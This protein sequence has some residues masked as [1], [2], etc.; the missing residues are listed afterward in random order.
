MI[1]KKVS[2]NLSW[3]IAYNLVLKSQDTFQRPVSFH[4]RKR[5]ALNMWCLCIT[6]LKRGMVEREISISFVLALSSSTPLSLQKKCIVIN[7]KK[8][9]ALHCCYFKKKCL[10]L[11][12]GTRKIYVY[13]GE[14]I[15]NNK[16]W[17][18]L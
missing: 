1:T 18:C 15:L 12:N 8:H 9:L 11:W 13:L 10:D 2:Y 16:R 17:N 6:F 4:F 3:I 14:L 5:Q 7:K